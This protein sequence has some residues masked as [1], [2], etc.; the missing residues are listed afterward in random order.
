MFRVVDCWAN[1]ASKCEHASRSSR[2]VKRRKQETKVAAPPNSF[3]RN[4]EKGAFPE[5]S[6][7]EFLYL[8]D[9]HDAR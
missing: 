6:P 3:L 7:R 5:S 8:V 4:E 1:T 2:K 9:L